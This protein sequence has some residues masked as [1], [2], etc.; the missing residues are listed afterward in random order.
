MAELRE[1]KKAELGELRR[2]YL[3]RNT[4]S[5]EARWEPARLN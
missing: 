3:S 5:E 1:T 2:E 4:A